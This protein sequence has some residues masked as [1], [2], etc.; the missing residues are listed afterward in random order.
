MLNKSVRNNL[1]VMLIGALLFAAPLAV[2]YPTSRDVGDLLAWSSSAFVLVIAYR[3][4]ANL[5]RQ[6]LPIAALA[7][8]GVATIWWGA[9]YVFVAWYR[10]APGEAWGNYAR[11]HNAIGIVLQCASGAVAAL[12]ACRRTETSP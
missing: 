2:A 4:G 9:L 1:L 5:N 10:I 7:G 6:M 3:F 11:V 12:A 8:I